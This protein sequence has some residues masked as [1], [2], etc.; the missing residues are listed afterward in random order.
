MQ[1]IAYVRRSTDDKK[2]QIQSIPNQ[3][4]WV[5]RTAKNLGVTVLKTFIDKQ[6]ATKPGR[7][8][9][10][11]MIE[12]VENSPEPMGIL[13]WKISR[14]ARNPIDEGAI[15]YAFMRGK[16]KHIYASDRQF[17]EGENQILMGVEFGA[18]TQFSVELSRSTLFGMER[19]IEMGYRPTSVPIG[20]LNDPY[21]LQGK[22]KIYKDPE[23]FRL[24][25]EAWKK[26]LTGAY[27]IENIRQDLNNNG[28]T[29][30]TGRP[31]PRSSLHSIFSNPFYCGSFKWKGQIYEGKHPAMVSP[32]DF[33]KVQILL[34]K[35]GKTR[36]YNT[37]HILSGLLS[38]GECGYA[39]T[40]DT[41][42]KKIHKT[43]EIRVYNYMRCTKKH[44][45]MK[46]LQPYIRY[47]SLEEQIVSILEK[48]FIAPKCIDWIF[49]SLR[50]NSDGIQQSLDIKKSSLQRKYNEQ[51][52]MTAEL[53]DNFNRKAVSLE[54]YEKTIQRYKEKS[55]QLKT[56]LSVFNKNPNAW[57][58]T[59]Y[60]DFCF[61]S[62]AKKTFIKSKRNKKREIICRVGSN[63]RLQDRKLFVDLHPQYKLLT[64][65]QEA[66]GEQNWRIEPSN[67]RSR[68]GLNHSLMRECPRWRPLLD[69]IRTIYTSMN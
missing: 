34:G 55:L 30:R 11:A 38:C 14:L 59:A 10:N 57:I 26:L 39:I 13:S 67:I 45:T 62:N 58:D 25:K 4:D 7:A 5:K 21:G 36:A 15:K 17:R 52:A 63:W 41:K 35:T 27:T 43:G 56:Q 22:K 60:N 2:K 24:L 8:G 66:L 68:K 61:A 48:I 64:K 9:F 51:E 6:T 31:I 54:Q 18:A 20:Y 69:D 16:I 44:P 19:K 3:L 23:R 46:C 53:L 29:T 42:Q 32:D 12:M 65:N 1:Y 28:F 50:F 40:T 49:K 37:Q 47:E 33:G